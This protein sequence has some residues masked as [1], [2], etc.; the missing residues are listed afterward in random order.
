[1]IYHHKT[2]KYFDEVLNS[3]E[4]ENYRSSVVTTGAYYNQTYIQTHRLTKDDVAFFNHLAKEKGIVNEF[5]DLMIS[6]Y[7]HTGSYNGAD[8]KNL[9]KNNSKPY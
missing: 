8:M 2:K 6:H 7:Y 5:Y 4:N 1:M 9:I 3:F